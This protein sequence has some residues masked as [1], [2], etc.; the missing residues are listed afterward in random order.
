MLDLRAEIWVSMSASSVGEA[1]SAGSC[2]SK[3]NLGEGGGG[4]EQT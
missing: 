2:G 4:K 1:A 3:V